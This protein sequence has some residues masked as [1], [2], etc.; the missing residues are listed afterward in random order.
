MSVSEQPQFNVSRVIVQPGPLG[1]PLLEQVATLHSISTTEFPPPVG[2]LG[3]LVSLFLTPL[4]IIDWNVD[5]W[6]PWDAKLK[7][8]YQVEVGNAGI[9]KVQGTRM[10]ELLEVSS[11]KLLEYMAE[12][13]SL[14]S[15]LVTLSVSFE[16]KGMDFLRGIL[17]LVIEHTIRVRSQATVTGRVWFFPVRKTFDI[18]ATLP[19]A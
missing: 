15:S 17:S 5:L 9:A 11:K 3:S 16:L 8:T 14:Q 18:D 1:T 7:G 19:V 4:R 12:P 2:P 10:Q 6:P 13:G